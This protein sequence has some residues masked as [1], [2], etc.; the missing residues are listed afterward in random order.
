M[1]G[2]LY[3][4]NLGGLPPSG[5]S[6]G[7]AGWQLVFLSV[8]AGAWVCAGVRACGHAGVCRGQAERRGVESKRREGGRGATNWC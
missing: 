7:L 4:T 5:T 8:G 6:T 2:G 3:A 1:L